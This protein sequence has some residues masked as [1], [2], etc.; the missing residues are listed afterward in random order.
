MSVNVQIRPA[1]VADIAAMSRLLTQLFSI[2]ADFK[3]DEG[4]Q[5]RGLQLLLDSA[6]GH[7]VVAEG[8]GAVIGMATLQV[9]ISTAEGGRV[10]L[11]EDVIVDQKFRGRG[12]GTAL[13]DHLQQWAKEHDL[14][15]L[16]L[17]ADRDNSAALEFYA[18]NGWE[19]T[20]LVMLRYGV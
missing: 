18:R 12:V 1:N 4:K 2:E 16:Q 6:D 17:A 13:L 11:V 15:R 8:Q 20:S 19:Q 14:S 3:P 5:R 10:G 7:C 9:L